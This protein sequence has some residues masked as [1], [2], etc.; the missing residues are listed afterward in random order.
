M[1]DLSFQV[2]SVAPEPYSAAP[3]LNFKIKVEQRDGNA[4]ID[5]IALRCQLRLEPTRRRY[6][7]NEKDRLLELFGRP[8]QWSQTLRAM[9]WTHA[10]TLVPAFTSGTTVDLPVPCTYDFSIAMTKYFDALE[11]GDVPLSLLFSGTIFYR[12]EAGELQ[13]APIPWDKDADFRLPASVWRE[14]MQQH[15]PNQAWLCLR[16]DAFDRFRQFKIQM[17]HATWEQALDDLLQSAQQKV[18]E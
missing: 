15:F 10:N 16:K 17:G 9:L 4:R 18:H 3:L 8:S 12:N 7:D 13:A 1:P 11:H 2:V 5:T 14:M 6:T